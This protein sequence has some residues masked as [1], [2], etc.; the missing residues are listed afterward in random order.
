MRRN[1]GFTLIEL[2]VV[3][4][5]IGALTAI[6]I[7]QY[8]EYRKRGFD[9]RAQ[10]D[11]R[12]VAIAEEAYFLDAEHYLS[13][14]ASGCAA[15]PGIA[16]LSQGVVLQIAATATGFTGTSRHPSGSGELFRWD[17]SRGGLQ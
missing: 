15:L 3:M 2:L 6:A 8:Q 4:T 7:P 1:T 17:S 16:R 13:C 11:L 5:I 12:N 14:Q 9:L 10:S